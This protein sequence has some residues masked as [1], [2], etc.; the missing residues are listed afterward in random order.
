MLL[1]KVDRSEYYNNKKLEKDYTDKNEN[2]PEHNVKELKC[3][4]FNV[5]MRDI[6]WHVSI[7]DYFEPY[8][9]RGGF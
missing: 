9:K 6:Y 3:I 4:D 5:K 8:E 2:S 7:I 1:Y